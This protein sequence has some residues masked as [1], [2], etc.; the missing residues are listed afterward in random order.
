MSNEH[1]QS[2]ASRLVGISYS[3]HA[4]SGVKPIVLRPA[5]TWFVALCLDSPKFHVPLGSAICFEAA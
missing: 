5:D 1:R 3:L 4:V 2:R